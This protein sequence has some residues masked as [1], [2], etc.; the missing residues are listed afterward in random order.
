MKAALEKMGGKERLDVENVE[1]R[2]EVI[3]MDIALVQVIQDNQ[4]RSH[5]FTSCLLQDGAAPS[6]PWTSDSEADSTPSPSQNSYTSDTDVS[7]SSSCS[8]SSEEEAKKAKSP[9][10]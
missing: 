3:E 6:P 7:S 5:E 2:E 1:G 4:T 10:L 8:S 9:D